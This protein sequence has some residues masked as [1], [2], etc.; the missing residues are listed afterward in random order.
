MIWSKGR[1]NQCGVPQ[2]PH[3]L[4]LLNVSVSQSCLASFSFPPTFPV[5]CCGWTNLGPWLKYLLNARN[6]QTFISGPAISPE[7][8]NR[9]GRHLCLAVPQK[10]KIQHAHRNTSCSPQN[11]SP[12]PFTQRAAQVSNLNILFSLAFSFASAFNQSLCSDR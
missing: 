9:L 2:V 12:L 7:H 5:L 3:V 6:A 1:H 10:L 11:P 8:R 4:L